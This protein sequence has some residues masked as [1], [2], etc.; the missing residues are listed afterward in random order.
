MASVYDGLSNIY[1][2]GYSVPVL[3]RINVD[4]KRVDTFNLTGMVANVFS[5]MMYS[6][7]SMNSN[8]YIVGD[9]RYLAM[10]IFSNLTSTVQFK[11]GAFP[12]SSG[13]EVYHYAELTSASTMNL[14]SMYSQYG[15]TIVQSN[16]MGQIDM[17]NRT[18]TGLSVFT[19]QQISLTNSVGLWFSNYCANVQISN[20]NYMVPSVPGINFG[21]LQSGSTDLATFVLPVSQGYAGA[22]SDGRYV[23]MVPAKG[24]K[25]MVRF[26][27][28]KRFS[29]FLPFCTDSSTNPSGSTNFS[30]VSMRIPGTNAGTVYAVNHNILRFR[31]GMASIL[32]AS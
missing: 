32:Y 6:N 29:M 10:D 4:T 1:T 9:N 20:I 8:L 11:Y 21:S 7:L 16:L 30:R 2:C 28:S 14:Y 23:Y 15:N 17:Y 13:S 25:N 27:S 5:L 3:Y 18:F 26:D 24:F 22:A 12:F 31:D 19:Q